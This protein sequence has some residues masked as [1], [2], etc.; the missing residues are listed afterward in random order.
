MKKFNLEKAL[1]GEPVV[2]RDGRPVTQLTLFEIESNFPL[3]GV[4]DRNF[5]TWTKKGFFHDVKKDHPYN[6]FMYEEKKSVW[7]NVYQGNYSKHLSVVAHCS[8]EQ[9]I[10]H[11]SPHNGFTYIKTVEITDEP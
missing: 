3:K 2:T 10:E 7:I 4:V 9:A 8:L 11:K 1:A 6:L 5:S